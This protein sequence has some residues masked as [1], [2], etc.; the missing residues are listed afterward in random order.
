MWAKGQPAPA[1]REL[2]LRIGLGHF[3]TGITGIRHWLSKPVRTPA[4][5]FESITSAAKYF[6][7]TK[8]N[9]SILA[10][11]GTEGYG[12]GLGVSVMDTID[13]LSRPSPARRI[14]SSEA[15]RV[16]FMG[17]EIDEK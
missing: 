16:G 4:G 3:N 10:I 14:F 7:F 17:R 8:Q 5:I 1:Q 6:G 11:R 15:L 9:A 2:A 13:D 12:Y